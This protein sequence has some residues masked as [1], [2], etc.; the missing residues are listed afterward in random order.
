MCTWWLQH[1]KL[2]VMFRVSPARLQTFIDTP[3]CVLEDR[4]QYST[5]HIPNVFCDGHLHLINCVGIVRIH[6]VFHRTPE[7]K[8]GR[9]K[10]RR[11]WRPNGFRND[12]VPKHVVQE[13][14]RYMRCMNRSAILLKVGLA[15][16][17]FFQ[18]RIERIH[19]IVT[20]PLGVESLR[21]KKWVRLCAYAT[22]Q[23]CV[24]FLL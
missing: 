8:I 13:C 16:L 12:S 14:Y 7:K 6:W 10:I 20:V 17:I 4:V 1:R 23:L 21:E 5:V 9:R 19:N 3:N 15:N 2:Q 24:F 11:S 22:F 18:L